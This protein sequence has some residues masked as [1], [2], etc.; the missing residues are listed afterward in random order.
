MEIFYLYSYKSFTIS[1]D[2]ALLNTFFLIPK[3]KLMAPILKTSYY[4]NID[5]KSLLINFHITILPFTQLCILFLDAEICRSSGL[6]CFLLLLIEIRKIWKY[7]LKLMS[8]VSTSVFDLLRYSLIN[9][10][11]LEVVRRE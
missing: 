11:C 9:T 3:M 7:L 5:T 2:V 4:K 1:W 6:V 8:E 10:L